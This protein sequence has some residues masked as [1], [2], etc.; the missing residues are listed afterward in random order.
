[1]K[2]KLIEINEIMDLLGVSDHRT[3]RK[4][5]KT[6]KLPLFTLGKKTY[7]YSLF[8]NIFLE[9]ELETFLRANYQNPKD[10]MEAIN[11]D[12]KI[13]LSQ[14]I[15]APVEKNIKKEYKK[16]IIRSKASQQFLK[17]IA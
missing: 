9:K 10:I 12:D 17:N 7:T 11:N 1:M 14:L 6:N 16:K 8:L 3:V 15:Q 4:F 2:D 5:C 13:E